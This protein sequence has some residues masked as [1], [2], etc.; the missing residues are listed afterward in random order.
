MG[1]VPTLPYYSDVSE[2]D[3]Y[4]IY[5]YPGST[6]GFSPYSGGVEN[7]SQN[8]GVAIG[9]GGQDVNPNA[10]MED[11]F[12]ANRNQI[13]EEGNQIGQEAGNELNYYQPLQQQYTSAE[14]A[15]LNNLAQTPGYTPGEAGQINVDYSQYDTTPGQYA[16]ITG[17]PNAPVS[18]VTSG[19]ANEGAMLNQYQANLGGELA[20]Y[21]GY[22]GGAT[23]AYGAGVGGA[24][25][26]LEIGLE[27]AQGKFSGLDTAVS[28]PALGFDPNST[29]KQMTNQD[30]QNLVTS[31]GTTVGNQFQAAKDQLEQRA[32]AQGN[33]SPEA[34]AAEEMALTTQGAATAGDAMTNAQIAANNAQYQRA[35]GI[36]Q[37]R[38]GATQTQAGLEATA[39]TTEEAAAQ[40]AA[41]QAG[42]A[43]IG[44]QENIGAQQIGAANAIG[45]ENVNAANTYGQYSTGEENTM[46]NQLYPA[47][48]TAE[49]LASQRAAQNAQMQYGEGTGSAQLTSGGAQT[50]GNAR[51]AGLASYRSGVAGQ[52]QGAQQGGESALQAQEGAYG[53]QTQGVNQAAG[54]QAGF[55]V[56]KP[57]LGDSL[58]KTALGSLVSGFTGGALSAAQQGSGMFGDGGVAYHSQIAKLGEKGPELVREPQGDTLVHTPTI[59]RIAGGTQ[60]IPFKPSATNKLQPDVLEGKVNPPKV[61]GM[62]LARYRGYNRYAH[63]SGGMV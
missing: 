23:D 27:G 41:G 35:A 58:A 34:L 49:Q 56:G 31:A 39:A 46:T 3:P 38:E 14:N 36:E 61:P 5:G 25:S 13:S 1:S 21:S 45:Q 8:W 37:Q 6:N 59:A 15:A 42:Q 7:A 63:N 16:A 60:V 12:S 43:N 50:V 19:T 24:A 29:E 30:V 18:A 44:A 32:A 20:Q 33:T 52:Q 11:I 26:G 51:Q 2:Q 40:A 55:E 22:L 4:S 9:A 62:S 47:E 57:S 28:N 54:S 48:A 10:S 53:T 17:D